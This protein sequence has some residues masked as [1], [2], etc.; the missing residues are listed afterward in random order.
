METLCAFVV[1]LAMAGLSSSADAQSF[2]AYDDFSTKFIDPDKWLVPQ[3]CGDVNRGYRECVLEIKGGQM[4]QEN[5]T[6]GDTDSDS[7]FN[8]SGV[9][10]SVPNGSAVTAIKADVLVKDV[11]VSGCANNSNVTGQTRARLGGSFFNT[12]TNDVSATINLQR[13]PATPKNRLRVDAFTD[14]VAGFV[15]L[16]TIGK[17]ETVSLS[18]SW[19]QANHRFKFT[20]SRPT[21]PTQLDAFI[22]YTESDTTP[23]VDNFKGLS[24]NNI[25]PNCTAT[26]RPVAYMEALF[27]NVFVAP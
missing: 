9:F 24:V 10:L 15:A 16:G 5:R 23:P 26:P 11:E 1:L 6:Y 4:R 17:G 18:V 12:G 14:G 25:A 21:S 8:F 22:S 19:E 27:D 20:V 13:F 7:G 2:R 3:D